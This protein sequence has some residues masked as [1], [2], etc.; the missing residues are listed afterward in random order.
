[1][2]LGDFVVNN[3]VLSR[4]SNLKE[5]TIV[6]WLWTR[7]TALSW[8]RY[9]HLFWRRLYRNC[10]LF[11]LTFYCFLVLWS[12][13]WVVI[14][15]VKLENSIVWWFFGWGL[16]R[17]TVQNPFGLAIIY[18]KRFTVTLLYMPKGSHLGLLF[19][20]RDRYFRKC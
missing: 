16:I 18:L 11:Y 20:Q 2:C 12:E 14:G 7:K 19:W 13:S 15:H 3:S 1:M 10:L 6:F 9:L 8:I 4:W 17:P 5:E